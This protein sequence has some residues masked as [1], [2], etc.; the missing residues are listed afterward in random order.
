M[1]PADLP[2]AD[3]ARSA[4]SRAHAEHASG[5]AID[6]RQLSHE[7]RT[8][9]NAILGN[10]ELLLDGSTG[11]LSAQAR[12][13]LGEIQIAGH[14]LLRQVQ[15]LLAWSELGASQR[16]LAEGRVDLIALVREALTDARPEGVRIDP[17]DAALSIWGDRFWLHML[18]AEIIALPEPSRAV[19]T[20]ALESSAKDRALRFTWPD[21][22]AAQTGGLQRALIEA[23]ARLQGAAVVPNAD[24]LSLRWSLHQ[25]AWPRAA[26]SYAEQ[27]CE[28]GAQQPYEPAS[29]GAGPVSSPHDGE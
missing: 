15:L 14:R 22:A 8:P 16:K 2:V 1:P 18:V 12:A 11:P 24:G 23:I 26:A 28:P 5:T 25:L 21:F 27:G 7:L 29:S 9:L 19:P 20:I 10:A 4:C 17:H 3:S 6:W 13:C